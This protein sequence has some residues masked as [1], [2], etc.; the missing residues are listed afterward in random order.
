[1][2]NRLRYALDLDLE[3]GRAALPQPEFEDGRL[4]IRFWR[5]VGKSDIA[6]LVEASSDLVNWDPPVYDSRNDRD[7]S[8]GGG[9]VRAVDSIRTED[10]DR[11]ALRL[12]IEQVD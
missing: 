3:A 8:P 4:S 7:A 12:R 9:Y 11:R 10:A 6:Y 1:M 2:L 5:D